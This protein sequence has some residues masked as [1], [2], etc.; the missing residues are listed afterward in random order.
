MRKNDLAPAEERRSDIESYVKIL[1]KLPPK[2]SQ[3]SVFFCQRRGTDPERYLQFP[4]RID[5]LSG[6]EETC[7]SFSD[8]SS[9]QEGKNTRQ[10]NDLLKTNQGKEDYA[11][12]SYTNLTFEAS[13]SMEREGPVKS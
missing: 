10:T 3:S 1:I 13:G 8:V 6:D 4:Q 9:N 2:I 11:E 7:T 5:R 12:V